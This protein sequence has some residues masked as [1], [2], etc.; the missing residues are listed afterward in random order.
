MITL[1]SL[2]TRHNSI[3]HKDFVSFECNV[4][5]FD[6]IDKCLNKLTPDLLKQSGYVTAIR[7][8]FGKLQI[9]TSVTNRKIDTIIMA[10]VDE[11]CGIC[12]L[13]GCETARTRHS[14][15]NWVK[16]LCDECAALHNYK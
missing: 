5:W 11:S 13:C 3:L 10:C 4:G 14:S 12:E 16:T 1:Q 2:L 6:T 15:S 9:N 7:E 8:R